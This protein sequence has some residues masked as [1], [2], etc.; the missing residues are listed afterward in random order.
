MKHKNT[1]LNQAKI[2][3]KSMTPQEIKL[4]N[5]LRNNKFYGLKFRRQVPIGNYIADFVCELHNIIVNSFAKRNPLT[6]ISKFREVSL[7]LKF[8]PL[9]LVEGMNKSSEQNFMYLLH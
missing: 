1:T 4:W 6:R 8:F 7:N 2:L 9:P 3:R 5:I